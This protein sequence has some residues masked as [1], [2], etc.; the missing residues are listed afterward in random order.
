M[1][2]RNSDS[3]QRSNVSGDLRYCGVELLPCLTARIIPATRN[4]KALPTVVAGFAPKISSY[5]AFRFTS[6]TNLYFGAKAT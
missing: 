3:G 4:S 5:E 2:Y 1:S 6:D